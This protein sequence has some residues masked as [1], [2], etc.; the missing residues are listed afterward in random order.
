M[1]IPVRFAVFLAC[2]GLLP[3][4][5]LTI[6]TL[7]SRPDMV[8]GG[9][10]LVEIKGASMKLSVH[11]NGSDVAT[12]FQADDSRGSLVGLVRGLKLG[13]NTLVAKAGSE[14]V[15][16]KLVNHPITGPIV[17]GP[18]LNP[19][20]CTTKESGLGEPLDENCSAQTKVE[21]FYKPTEGAFKP[22][23][24]YAN[25]IIPRDMA[26]TTT[27]E[28]KTVDYIVRVES[29][30]INRSI[31]RIAILDGFDHGMH[32]DLGI[33]VWRPSEV[34]N[35]RII[36]SFGGGCGTQYN[37]GKNTAVSAI[38][39]A[40]L[41]RGFAH[42]ISTQNVMNQHCNDHLSGE[43]LMMIKEHFIKRYGVPVWTM[44]HG[45]SGGSIQQLLIAQNFPGLLD[46]LL[47]SLT[48]PDSMSTRPGVTDCRLLMRTFA[49]DPGT[50]TQEKQTAVEGYTPGT[51]KAW[52]RSFIDVI[53]AANAKGC[54]IAPELVYDP[55]KN[56]K[57]A[58]CTIWEMNAATV[59]RDPATGYARA[60]LDNV[61]VQYGLEALNNGKISKQEFLDLNRNIGGYDA[62]GVPR[63]QRTVADLEA[64]R[65]S[66]ITGRINSGAGGLAS[67]PILHYRPYN[68][69]LGD[70]HDRF[71][72]FVV[73]ERLRK[74]N[75]RVD[76][77]VLWVYPAGD[78]ALAAKVSGLAI[79][80]MTQWLDTKT[81]PAAAV[82]GCWTK[83]G[84][85]I[86]EPA[87]FDGPGKCNDL[88]PSHKNPRLVAGAP[89]TDDIA[90]CQLR[91]VN[92]ADYK[93]QFTSS[94]LQEL[95]AIFPGGVCDY[96][97]PGV[98]QL[99]LAGTYLTLPLRSPAPARGGMGA[100]VQR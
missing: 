22:Y 3:A 21:Y 29:G 69:P 71:R 84:S 1:L 80:T 85:R 62:D 72:D 24:E 67:V 95:R 6:T 82:D 36:Y 51:C 14:H 89:L 9:D 17:S 42:I 40:A 77:Q 55:V 56:P 23:P 87:T 5:S 44:G 33:R 66:Y 10:A 90:K 60:A 61:G 35:H 13:A 48:Y 19:F 99:P 64:L 94:E 28:G 8:S 54:A 39:D 53:V 83:E 70:I 30:T 81:K 97:K 98:M 27:S 43:A 93:V 50:W 7:S 49:K 96:S 59:G 32:G 4:A 65:M 79:D 76:N 34:W 78:R 11:L 86:D 25:R 57:G 88:F 38:M 2:A 75:G 100:A 16:L 52:D 26:K 73:R 63:A 92:P 18:H 41:S 45:G 12:A 58:R 74:T 91:P 47:P 46:G 68:D 37:Q 15:T 20:I 31:Y